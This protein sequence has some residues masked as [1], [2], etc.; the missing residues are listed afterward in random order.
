[1][2]LNIG[3]L[4]RINL[5][6]SVADV[7]RQSIINGKITAGTH[8]I[9][10]ELSQQLNV[11]RGPLREA[12]RILEAEGLLESHPGRGVYVAQPSERFICES[13]SLRNLLEEEALKLAIQKRTDQDL[14]HLENALKDLF[15][16]AKIGNQKG[17][18]DLDIAFH[19]Q[20]WKIADHQLI[21]ASLDE[22]IAHQKMYIAVQTNIFEDLLEGVS[23]HQI[24]LESLRNK[25]EAL[26]REVLKKHLQ[27]A[28]RMI[29]EYF[30]MNCQ[31]DLSNLI[32][33]Q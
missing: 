32:K 24:I 23:D 31:P 9:E 12:F 27:E 5:A 13:Y 33:P 16:A 26:G 18:L 8:L 3:S 7:L 2:A 30:H 1:M 25:N 21:T 28:A 10:N 11:S 6:E 19:R 20:I 17:V 14:I 4:E 15:E 29:M 22:I